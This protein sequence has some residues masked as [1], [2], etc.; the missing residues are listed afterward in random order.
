MLT[1]EQKAEQK[2]REHSFVHEVTQTPCHAVEQISIA[3]ELSRQANVIQSSVR[4]H[5]KAPVSRH[6][7]RRKNR[8]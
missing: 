7:E 4:L 3:H 6:V 2:Q 5:R 1:D 8:S